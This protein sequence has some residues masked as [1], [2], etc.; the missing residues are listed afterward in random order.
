MA[1]ELGPA[2]KLYDLGYLTSTFVAMAIYTVLCKISPPDHIAEA[3]SM[4]FET[5]GKKE[6][7]RGVNGRNSVDIEDVVI[8]EDK[9]I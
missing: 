6:V 8:S 2:K 4:P 3:R 9:K 1:A 5:M 7:L